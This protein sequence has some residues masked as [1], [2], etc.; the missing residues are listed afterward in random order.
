MFNTKNMTLSPMNGGFLS[1]KDIQYINSRYQF[2]LVISA[3]EHFVQSEEQE[4]GDAAQ[5]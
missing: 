2:L 3:E 1:N 5:H 4:E